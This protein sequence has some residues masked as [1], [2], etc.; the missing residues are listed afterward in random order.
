[1]EQEQKDDSSLMTVR[2]S[3]G[4][5]LIIIITLIVLVSL[6]SITALVSI[7]VRSDLRIAA[8]DNNFEVNRRSAMWAE[9]TFVNMRSNSTI[10][11][12]TVNSL[13]YGSAAAQQAAQLFFEQNP[14][15][16]LLLFASEGKLRQLLVNR[17]FFLTREVDPALADSFSDNYMA[18][19]RRTAL[20]ETLILNLTPWFKT[21][22]LALLY[23]WQGG[24]AGVLFSPESLSDNFGFGTNQSCLINDS[25]DTLVHADFEFVRNAVNVADKNFTSFVWDNPQRNAQVLYT[26]EDGL[27]YF[28]AFTKLNIGGAVVITSIEYDKVF[29]GIAATT[30]RNIYLTF[31]V[32]SI[33]ILLIWFFSKS[34]SVRLKSLASAA[35][36]IEGGEFELELK[37]RGRDEIGVLTSSF[38]RMCTALGIF[39]RFTNKEIAVRAMRGEIKPGGMPKHATIFFSDIRGFTEKS[40]KITQTYGE[41]ASNRIVLW[42]NDYLTRMVVCVEKTGGVVDKF[43][44][45]AVMAHWGTAYSSG[46]PQKDAFNCIKAA[47]MMRKALYEMNK[48]RSTEDTSNPPIRIGCGINSGIVTA[49]QIGSDLRMEYTVIGDPVNLASRT[50]SLNKPLATDILIT[51]DTWKLIK[52]DFITEEMPPVTV[53]GKEKPVRI[54][55]I[56]NFS[57]INKGPKTLADVRKLLGINAPDIITPNTGFNEK[58][59][60]IG[61]ENSREQK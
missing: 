55:A 34:I 14:Q 11:M 56:I 53:K 18:D 26:D 30:R 10:L 15:T 2:F 52:N 45:D 32:L 58:K 61:A 21:P 24:S 27:R 13:G 6:G 39:G 50:E 41:E 29:E 19:L 7:L 25:G 22:V 36:T 12:Q 33:S 31:T 5:K 47:L 54:F 40:E 57:G 38:M 23:P 48:T 17:N 37:P 20:G 28:G 3:I 43:I 60:S 4:A 59:Y 42:L 8:E 46:S 35:R 16:A 51:E 44:G 1:M 49:G 9:F